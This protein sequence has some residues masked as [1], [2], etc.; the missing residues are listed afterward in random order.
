MRYDVRTMPIFD[1]VLLIV[2]GGFVLYGLW[3]GLIQSVGSL[4]GIALA[5]VIAGQWYTIAP[6]GVSQLVAFILIGT[7]CQLRSLRPRAGDGQ[8]VN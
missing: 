8:T 3:F 2:L 4:V 5:A 1:L 6:E 7:V